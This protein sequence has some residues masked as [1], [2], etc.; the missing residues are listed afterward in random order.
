MEK[1]GEMC[2]PPLCPL[3]QVHRLIVVDED[4]KVI[5]IVSLSDILKFLVITPHE[6]G[7]DL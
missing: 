2:G 5:G 1:L 3:S 4:Q 6:L 7:T